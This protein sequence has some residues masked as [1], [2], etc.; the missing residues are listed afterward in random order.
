MTT[1]ATLK[2]EKPSAS[3]FP[4]PASPQDLPL[5][6][7]LRKQEIEAV[8]ARND[9]GRI[10]FALNGTVQ[11]LPV[12]YVYLNGWIYGRTAA[13][14]YLPGNEAV[15]FQVDERNPSQEWRTVVVNGRFDMVESGAA[16]QTR[17]VYRKV[18]SRLIG[19]IR[20]APVERSDLTFR[21]QLFVIKATRVSGLAS[22]PAEGTRFAS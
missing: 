3:L 17:R 5:F 14:N 2:K 1:A 9:V 18:L 15:A 22:L 4:V 7:T 20:P 8:L 12:H 6:R 10:A 16:E 19:V 21:D 11:L 13:L